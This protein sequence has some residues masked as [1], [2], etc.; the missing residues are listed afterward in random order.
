MALLTKEQINDILDITNVC[1]SSSSA[2]KLIGWNEKQATQQIEIDWDYAPKNATKAVLRMHW[3]TE[4]EGSELWSPSFD[5][6]TF[7]RPA[8]V[9][10]PHPHAEMMAKYA[11]V[12]ARRV[13]PWVEFEI[14]TGEGSTWKKCTSFICFRAGYDFRP[15]GE[16]E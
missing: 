16:E 11:E 13:D 9:I 12:A 7:E 15:I 10:T 4:S 14:K 5:S 8:P 2:K 3:V 1:F 6:V